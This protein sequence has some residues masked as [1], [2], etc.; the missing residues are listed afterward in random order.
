MQKPL[1]ISVSIN[2]MN[3]SSIPQSLPICWRKKN[4]STSGDFPIFLATPPGLTEESWLEKW[5]RNFPWYILNTIKN[6]WR[7][8]RQRPV[9]SL[10]YLK[11]L[12]F[13][14]KIVLTILLAEKKKSFFRKKSNPWRLDVVFFYLKKNPPIFRVFRRHFLI[15][16]REEKS[17][18]SQATFAET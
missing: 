15:L 18:A 2:G 5:A 7:K 14:G 17:T 11:I 12:F 16:S 3:I 13:H 10:D 4:A 6:S 1:G 8:S 9:S